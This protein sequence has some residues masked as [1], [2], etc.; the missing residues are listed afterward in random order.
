MPLSDA[1]ALKVRK[2]VIAYWNGIDKCDDL[3]GALSDL[4]REKE[5]AVTELLQTGQPSDVYEASRITAEFEYR[6]SLLS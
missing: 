1:D 3:D 2:D 4:V 6:R 5:I